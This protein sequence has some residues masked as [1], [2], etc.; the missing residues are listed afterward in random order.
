MTTLNLTTNVIGTLMDR[1]VCWMHL[2]PY[3][4]HLSTDP[5]IIRQASAYFRIF[6]HIIWIGW[7]DTYRFRLKLSALDVLSLITHKIEIERIYLRVY[8]VL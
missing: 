7:M 4:A 1:M 8:G 5:S 3:P 2:H 6:V